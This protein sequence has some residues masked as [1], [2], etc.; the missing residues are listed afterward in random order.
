MLDDVIVSGDGRIILCGH[1]IIQLNHSQDV[2]KDIGTIMLFK[3]YSNIKYKFMSLLNDT[4]RKSIISNLKHSGHAVSMGNFV[5]FSIENKPVYSNSHHSHVLYFLHQLTQ[6]GTTHDETSVIKLQTDS[7]YCAEIY[8]SK[9]KV[10]HLSMK[11]SNKK[12][13]H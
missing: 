9:F 1:I 8:N 12:H 10:I 7:L 4:Q 3:E 6:E 2:V 13:S 11:D 5:K